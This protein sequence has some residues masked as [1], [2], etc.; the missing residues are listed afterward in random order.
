MP[1]YSSR[2]LN[3]IFTSVPPNYDLINRLFTWRMDECWRKKTARICLE[4]HPEQVMDLCTGTGDLAVQ[5]ARLS[6]GNTAITGF[7]Y[8]QP[9]LDLAKQKAVRNGFETLEFIHG[10]AAAMP[11]P[12][13]HFD[14]IGI[15][16]AFRNLTYKNP[17]A[18]RFLHEINR[19]LKIGGR[20]VIVES[21]QP[22]NR[23]IRALFRLYTRNMVFIMGAFISKNKS[24]YR[25]LA[26]SVIHYYTPE[27][28][29]AL[30]KNHGFSAATHK[31][32]FFGA[33][34]IHTALK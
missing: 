31:P 25:Y 22:K 20:F 21:S 18:S 13:G 11:F 29:E 28:I 30:L 5:L 15:A 1:D 19:V 33:A 32:L 2:P 23:L 16:F 12:D 34:A 26:Q 10:D 24:A 9:M 4:E 3:K 8:S 7:D 14:A 6:G 27:E 17:D